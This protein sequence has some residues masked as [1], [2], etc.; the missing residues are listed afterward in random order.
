MALDD[1]SLWDSN[2]AFYAQTPRE[3]IERGDWSVPYFN[4]RPRLTKPPLSYWV[5]GFFYQIFSP[6]VF[7]ERFPLALLA[8]GSV[9]A[10][11]VSGKGLYDEEVA[12]WAAGIFATTFRFLILGRRL[13]IDILLLFCLLWAITFFLSWMRS[14]KKSHFIL[15]SFLF[16][17]GFFSQRARCLPSPHLPGVLSVDP[18]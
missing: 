11:F 1:S 9:L 8:Y 7:W 4:G 14:H 6:T 13:M 12:L 10:V 2:E 3:M 18:W 16:G 17:L 5:V 15:A